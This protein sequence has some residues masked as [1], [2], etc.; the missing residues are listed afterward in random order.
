MADFC[1]CNYC[2]L[3]IYDSNVLEGHAICPEC[4]SDE[5][6]MDLEGHQVDI[7]ELTED[8]MLESWLEDKSYT[9]HFVIS[10]NYDEGTVLIK[11]YP[12]PISC[13]DLAN[14]F[15]R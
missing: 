7:S 15:Q 5:Y 4:N 6:L 10:V 3:I 12:N 13:K 2:G 9:K 1:K 11:D 14:S 8:E